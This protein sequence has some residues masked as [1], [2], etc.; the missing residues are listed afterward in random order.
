MKGTTTNENPGYTEIMDGSV[1]LETARH[2]WVSVPKILPDGALHK[3][4]KQREA[5]REI[6]LQLF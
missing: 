2:P 6:Q 3:D 1:W 5:K 4:Q